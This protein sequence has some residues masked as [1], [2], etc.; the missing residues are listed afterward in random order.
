M[1]DTDM[2]KNFLLLTSIGVRI[3]SIREL[4]PAQDYGDDTC[5][6]Y[7]MGRII[8]AAHAF[9]EGDLVVA[10]SKNFKDGIMFLNAKCSNVD[11]YLLPMTLLRVKK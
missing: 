10:R 6:G 5:V 1:A 4:E 2:K 11:Y 3:Y 8:K 7:Q 9:D